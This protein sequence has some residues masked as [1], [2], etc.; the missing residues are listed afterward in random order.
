MNELNNQMLNKEK[1][2]KE[3]MEVTKNT[4]IETNQKWMQVVQELLA[5]NKELSSMLE[6]QS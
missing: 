2:F 6:K 3:Y 5:I 1:R 4:M